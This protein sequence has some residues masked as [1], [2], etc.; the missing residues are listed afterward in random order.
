MG[1]Q[2]SGAISSCHIN[3][4]FY[5]YNLGHAMTV[6]QATFSGFLTAKSLFSGIL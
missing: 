4:T 6:D 5:L 1:P 3:G 2:K